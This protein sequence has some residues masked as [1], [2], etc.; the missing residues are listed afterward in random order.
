[1]KE[2]TDVWFDKTA[3]ALGPLKRDSVRVVRGDVGIDRIP[4]LSRAGEVGTSQGMSDQQT[5]PDPQVVEPGGL[6]G[7]EIQVHSRILPHPAVP[8]GFVNVQVVH[9]HV[10]LA[11]GISRH[12]F[13]PE[14][15]E[16]PTRTPQKVPPFTCPLAKS[17]AASRVEVPC[18]LYS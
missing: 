10:Q 15:E 11:L 18:C 17:G 1:M 7:R 3:L 9:D 4:Q 2:R 14:G 16:I 13:V 5:E 12:D 8:P 6:R